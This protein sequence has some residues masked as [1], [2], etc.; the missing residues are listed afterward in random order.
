MS[1]HMD[2]VLGQVAAERARQIQ[3][4]WTPEHDDL[5]STHQMVQLARSRAGRVGSSGEGY[6][7]RERLIEAAAIFVAAVEAMDRR[8]DQ[9]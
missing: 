6:Y 5:H 2:R 9:S 3:M 8:E 4:G 7:S 1:E